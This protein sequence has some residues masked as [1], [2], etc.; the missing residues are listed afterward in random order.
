MIMVHEKL[1]P[2]KA[3]VFLVSIDKAGVWVYD[4]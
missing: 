3:R 2:I 4:A 1:T